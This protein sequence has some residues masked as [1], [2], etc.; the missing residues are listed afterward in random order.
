MNK[1]TILVGYG[2]HGLVAADIFF[3]SGDLIKGYCDN[4]EK[5]SNPSSIP[6]LG[7]EREF[8]SEANN[9]NSYAA[10]IAIG[11]AS[12]R[13]KVFEFLEKQRVSII[14]AIHPK[15]VLSKKAHLGRG[16]FIAANAVINAMCSIGNGVI[17][18]P[19]CSIDHEC[20][21]GDF[22]HICP[23]TILCGNVTIGKNSFIGAN[24]TV[25]PGK[26]IGDNIIVG[27]GS[28]VISN[29]SSPGVYAGSP[30]RL[31]KNLTS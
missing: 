6:Y 26:T 7:K 30:A 29:L 8:F 28:T 14:N 3:E 25:I 27:A 19:S 31:I 9:C 11:D 21:I 20:T 2:G 17:C 15:S 22:T 18:H 10:F 1:P 16:V 5:T 23:G 12:V 24:S 13:R 4:E